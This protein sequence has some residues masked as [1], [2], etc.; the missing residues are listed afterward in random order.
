[1]SANI[2]VQ[3]HHVRFY[4]ENGF[5][6]VDDMLTPDELEELR[7]YLEE[8]MAT[9]GDKAVKTDKKDGLYYRVLNQKVNT[10]RDHGGMALFSFHK[11][12]A[13]SARTLIGSKEVRF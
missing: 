6:K 3:D 1:M 2:P 10:W 4:E 8:A 12:L 7:E 5:V 13:E 9:D 11:R